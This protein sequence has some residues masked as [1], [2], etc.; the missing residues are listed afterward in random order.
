MLNNDKHLFGS[1]YYMVHFDNLES[2]FK[3]KCLLSLEKLRLKKIVVHSIANSNVQNLRDRI[4]IQWEKLR[5]LHSYVP[6][7][8]ATCTPM[9]HAQNISFRDQIV[10]LEV[11]RFILLEQG[12]IFTDG[13]ASNQQLS[14]YKNET[15]EVF[16]ATAKHQYCRRYYRL[17][18]PYGTN[19]NCSNLYADLM[20]LDHLNWNVICG[21]RCTTDEKRRMKQAE[22]L[23]PDQVP[24]SQIRSIFTCT[25][26]VARLVNALTAKLSLARQLPLAVYRPELYR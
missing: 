23:V 26:D 12:V 16:P 25:E 3:H 18:G 8:F 9:L 15:V 21:Q 17:G 5:S 13:N 2:I 14:K 1:I 24:I 4:F 6:F 20:F 22:V 10:I 11:S 7:Y 19:P